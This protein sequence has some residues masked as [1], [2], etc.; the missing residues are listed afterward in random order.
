MHKY[1]IK[2]VDIHDRTLV[3]I[4]YADDIDTAKNK[5]TTAVEILKVSD[6]GKLMRS[7]EFIR[8]M[9]HTDRLSHKEL[10]DI[11]R[12]ISY[13]RQS[14]L[15]IIDS[16]NVLSSTGSV[17][18]IML[19]HALLKS[20][21]EG[22]SLADAFAREVYRLP[23]DVSGIIAASSKA[24]TLNAV[25]LTLADQLESSIAITNKV[26]SAMMYPC[27]ILVIAIAV[28]CFLFV[29]IIPQV[30]TVIQGIGHTSLPDSTMT[31]LGI[32]SFLQENG[33]FVLTGLIIAIVLVGILFKK[34]IPKVKDFIVLH[35]PVIGSILRDEELVRFL[36]HFAFLLRAGFTSSDAV[37]AAIRVVNNRCISS[38]LSHALQ[39]IH[40]GYSLTAALAGSN[41]FT[42]LELQMLNV[43]E[44]S[45]NISEVCTT[46]A[47]QLYEK[48]E[49]H[50]QDMV[51]LIEPAIMIVVGVL[52]GIIMVAIYQ[53]LFELMSII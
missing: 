19:C 8:K 42:S 33:I 5:L 31:I 40:D 4:V 49:R 17:K 29:S 21:K 50:L 24:D 16:L 20:L 13:T 28:A 52:V 2:Y 3:D 53:P 35:I 45:G 38:N 26:R 27:I 18:Q 32:S 9:F 34:V 7:P 1:K 23:M 36:N 39:A 46:L 43:G 22:A 51:K 44:T 48:S 6:K 10:A 37:D 11:L 30:A 14:G 15:T 25:L 47:K 12:N 41:M